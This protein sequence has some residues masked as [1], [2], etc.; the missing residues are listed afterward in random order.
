MLTYVEKPVQEENSN[1]AHC[2][3]NIGK[4]EESSIFS[5]MDPD[6]RLDWSGIC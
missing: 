4:F 1:M 5:R 2:K 3:V 6:S